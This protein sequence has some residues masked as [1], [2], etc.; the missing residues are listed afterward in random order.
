MRLQEFE[1]RPLI[2]GDGKVFLQWFH[3]EVKQGSEDAWW[4]GRWRDLAQ[5][6]V[7]RGEVEEVQELADPVVVEGVEVFAVV[8]SQESQVG[9]VE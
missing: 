2:L 6:L 5:T 9:A 4:I 7:T 3:A 8:D 1:I